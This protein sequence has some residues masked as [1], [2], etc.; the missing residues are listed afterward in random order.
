MSNFQNNRFEE[1][2]HSGGFTLEFLGE[3]LLEKLNRQQNRFWKK[4]QEGRSAKIDILN[5]DK[6]THTV[7]DTEAVIAM[8]IFI[9][10]VVIVSTSSSSSYS[11][12]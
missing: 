5:L 4:L 2:F 9:F 11:S 8:I 1:V 7:C 12:S 6:I 10:T 3:V